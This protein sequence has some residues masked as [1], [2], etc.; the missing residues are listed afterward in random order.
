MRETPSVESLSNFLAKLPRLWRQG[1]VRPT[2]AVR[3]RGPRHWRTRKGPFQGVW[4][5]VLTWLETEPGATS[6]ALIAR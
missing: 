5:N 4:G 1:E 3:A 2:H 6:K